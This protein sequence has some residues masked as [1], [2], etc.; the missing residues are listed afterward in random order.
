MW[1]GIERRVVDR[2][3]IER[4][5]LLTEIHTNTKDLPLKLDEHKKWDDKRFLIV[6]L[7]IVVV[8]SASGVLTSVVALLK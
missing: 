7:A 8:A 1:D 2:D 3:W 6:Y 5:R 4:D